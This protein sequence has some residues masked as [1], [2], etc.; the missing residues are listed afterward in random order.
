MW[1]VHTEVLVC[2]TLRFCASRCPVGPSHIFKNTL[3]PILRKK[4][5]QWGCARWDLGLSRCLG[6][7]S[8][9]TVMTKSKCCSPLCRDEL[10]S[11]AAKVTQDR[12]L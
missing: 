7:L 5:K 2:K 11:A 10:N 1:F 6:R 8:K 4:N 9:Q 3:K 12:Y